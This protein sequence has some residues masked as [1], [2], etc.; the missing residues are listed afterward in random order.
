M[1][2]P[3]AEC[4]HKSSFARTAHDVTRGPLLEQFLAGIALAIPIVGRKTVSSAIRAID[5]GLDA[6]LLAGRPAQSVL[7]MGLLGT[8][9]GTTTI[10]TITDDTVPQPILGGADP[11]LSIQGTQIAHGS[12]LTTVCRADKGAL[13]RRLSPTDQQK[14][15]TPQTHAPP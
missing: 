15:Q 7:T 10:D 14:R 6:G 5:F 12:V 1:A 9:A 13:P 4:K 8:V 2:A 3:R 11:G